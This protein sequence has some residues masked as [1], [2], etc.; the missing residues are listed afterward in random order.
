MSSVKVVRGYKTEL[1]LNNAQI[2]ACRK[3]AWVARFAYN[4]GLRRSQEER[5]A[6]RNAPGAISLHKELNALKKT[7]Y[8]W[9]YEV[10]KCAAQEA[11]RDLEQAFKHFFRKC[12]L[13]KAGQWRG[14]GSFRFTGAIHVKENVVQLPR[15]GTLRLKERGY[16][17]TSGVKILSATV[18]E[19]AGRWF[20][21]LQVEE[22]G[23][24][25][26]RATGPIIGVDVGIKT[27]A[28][29]SDGSS[30]ENPKALRQ[31][32]TKLKRLS[33]W[34][35]RKQKG[36]QNRRR[37]T[38]KLVRFHSRVAQRLC[39]KATG[40]KLH[41]RAKGVKKADRDEYSYSC[42]EEEIFLR[43]GVYIPCE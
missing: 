26:V 23:T 14:R 21:S 3:H 5:Q 9:M 25:P 24:D 37:A 39:L 41:C 16:L 15:L 38:R 20:V 8:P 28:T 6:G 13:K 33:R 17:P 27:L 11:L 40:A 7:D 18:S 36:S 2:T 29:L 12:Q 35:S 30:I 32:L 19:Q 10:S 42:I 43:K 1:D 22:E 4:W 31:R 34:H